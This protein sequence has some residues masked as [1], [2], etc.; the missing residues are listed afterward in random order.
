MLTT[1]RAYIILLFSF[2]FL[3]FFRLGAQRAAL[4]VR[5]GGVQ[6]PGS[7]LATDTLGADSLAVDTPVVTAK[8]KSPLEAPV[9]YKAS[10]SIVFMGN[11]T[12]YMYGDGVVT[13]QDIELDAAEI[14]MNLDSSI[15]SAVGRP[16]SVGELVGTP[17]F[18]DKSGEYN[19]ETMRYSFDTQKGYITNIITQQG[20]G[21]LTGGRTK[22]MEDGDF[23]MVDGKY[24][25]CDDHECPHF[26]LQLTKAK[27]RPKR[28]IVTGPAY[29]VLADVPLPLV[30]PFGFFPFTEKYS[31]GIIMPTF[32]DEMT[33]GFYLRD[34]GYYFAISDYIDLALTGEIYTKGSWG[35]NA[36]SNYIKRYKYSGSFNL[37]Y[38]ITIT[39][40]K[41]M[42]D[43]Q[44]QKNFR[45]IWNHS[46]D[47]KANPNMSFSAS[48]NFTTS[49][50]DR[51]NIG[52][53]YNPAQF[54]E[55]TKSSTVNMTYNFPNSPFSLSATAN[56]TQRTRD[57][58]LNVSF[59]DLTLN[60]SRIYP[61]RRKEQVGKERWYEKISL[62]YTAMFR[63]SIQTK[64]D[65]FFKSSLIRDWQN[66]I[67]HRISS[68]ATFN[69]FKYINLTPSF[70]FNDRMYTS[71]FSEHWDPVKNAAVRDTTYGFYNF[72]NFNFNVTA[73]TKLY[74]FYKPLPFLGD[75]IQM[76]RHVFTPSVTFTGAPD[77]T[78]PKFGFQKSYN[79][80]DA[81][82]NLINKIYYPFSEGIFNGQPTGRTGLIQMSVANNLEMKVKS[83][84]DSTGVRKIS[85][86]ENLQA[87]MSYNMAAD[88]MR[89][90]NLNTSILIKLT[91]GFNLQASAEFDTY[92]Y[93]LNSAGQPIRVNVPRW[94]VG[95]GIGRLRS[96]GTSFSYTFNNDTFKKKKDSDS[97]DQDVPPV[98]PEEP[99]GP[100]D[101]D[102][103]KPQESSNSEMEMKDG[104]MVWRVPWSL[105]VN[106]SIS[107]AYDNS[108]FN[109]RKMEYNRRVNQ[110]L[111]LS[112]N[113]SPTKNWSF[114][115]TASYDFNLK[116]IAYMNCSISRDLHCWQMSASFVPVGPY[117]SYNFNISVKSS[118]LQ[119]LKWDK[120]G[121]PYDTLDWY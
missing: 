101:N 26:Y 17:V 97:G 15:V 46:Q 27:V 103:Q 28:N 13:Y 19:S 98:V 114:N 45:V 66:G 86:I 2:C 83:D 121:S 119:D 105:S 65:L 87:S 7:I 77:F 36:Q 57:S 113:I 72:Y 79:Y 51:N 116:K 14:R 104:Y 96:T 78:N 58:T 118:L 9:D 92:T 37:G 21:Y 73:Q 111:S 48:V 61:F 16:D 3:L 33:R 12:A 120:S 18:K 99:T 59:P 82:G 76:I 106:Y 55:N 22:K 20:E 68:S 69:V 102:Q 74:G 24:T 64:Q 91:K 47:S 109:V 117:K 34:G 54:T 11:N 81:S 85:L 93:Q 1:N 50:Y 84:R 40:D 8:R 30:I 94:K 6:E 100:L 56:I 35:L 112:G 71:K 75:K 107:Y 29:L 62:N 10:D 110:N 89:W 4:S 42:P 49:G 43:Y 80:L 25:T 67:D 115:F 23:Y 53:Y 41:G 44:K 31:S 108:D 5:N 70:N 90:S 95:K 32:G 38:I 52:S 63:N 60:M 39:G 88:S